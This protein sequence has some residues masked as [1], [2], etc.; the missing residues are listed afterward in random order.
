MSLIL[1]NNIKT[2]PSSVYL[3]ED[4]LWGTS[5]VTP[6]TP[7]TPTP[8]YP[9]DYEVRFTFIDGTYRTIDYEEYGITTFEMS[10]EVGAFS[11]PSIYDFY[12][13]WLDDVVEIEIGDGIDSIY[14]QFGGY[15]W[16]INF[17]N[18]E[19]ITFGS[20]FTRTTTS[21]HHYEFY[22]FDETIDLSSLRE[23]V[24]RGNV[25][26]LNYAE[27]DGYFLNHFYD[28]VESIVFETNSSDTAYLYLSNFQMLTS[29]TFGEDFVSRIG[30]IFRDVSYPNL[31]TIYSYPSTAMGINL[32]I[33]FRNLPENGT[34]YVPQGSNY[35]AWVG[36][37]TRQLHYWEIRDVL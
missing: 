24:F 19:R 16:M 7:P 15:D 1:N 32:G 29:V 33:G 25:N 28:N 34:L 37:E 5:D 20:G 6:P 9:S 17:H 21:R 27:D 14:W 36:D 2:S 23:L 30:N 13:K 35:D 26:I 8:T 22:D 12:G 18:L 11:D 4:M 31:L 3:G 10:D